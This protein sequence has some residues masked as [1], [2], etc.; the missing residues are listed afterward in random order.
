MPVDQKQIQTW[1]CMYGVKGGYQAV[2]M[3]PL[4]QGIRYGSILTSVH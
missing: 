2:A 1:A 4:P 3:S